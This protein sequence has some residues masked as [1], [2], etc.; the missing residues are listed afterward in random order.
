MF[1]EVSLLLIG[2]TFIIIGIINSKKCDPKR[3]E[4]RFVP[5]TFKEEQEN[6][7]GVQEI[8]N[9]MFEK[10]TPWIGGFGEPDVNFINRR[11]ISQ[12]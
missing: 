6:P 9:D 12:I 4:Y 8:F 7:V 1:L 10:P 5:R 11:F 3:I 2:L